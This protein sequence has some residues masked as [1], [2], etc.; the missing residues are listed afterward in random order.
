MIVE[1]EFISGKWACPR[2]FKNIDMKKLPMS[3]H[4]NRTSWINS[5]IFTDWLNEFDPCVEK[6]KCNILFFLNDAPVHPQDVQLDNIKLKFFPPQYNFKDPTDGS[7]YYTHVQGTLSSSFSQAHY[8][9]FNRC[10]HSHCFR[11]SALDQFG[12]GRC[13]SIHHNYD[14]RGL[15]GK[16][17]WKTLLSILSELLLRL[18]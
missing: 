5:W 16:I 9:K 14:D 6:Q 12:M 1:E 17:E 15:R 4:S 13:D 7:K 3:W 2:C 11:C 18:L 10:C 8:C